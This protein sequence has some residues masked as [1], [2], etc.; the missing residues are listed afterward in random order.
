MWQRSRVRLPA[1]KKEVATHA[2]RKNPRVDPRARAALP[3]QAAG[4][5]AP[6]GPSLPL[7]EAAGKPVR[8]GK[9]GF[10]VE[11]SR[12]QVMCRTG[13]RGVGQSHRIGLGEGEAYD[14]EESAVAVARAWVRG[15]GSC[16]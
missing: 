6:K 12:S 5:P 10:A 3:L 11:R 7:A 9:P 14:S 16:K 13:L 1:P 2:S 4:K 8:F 15:L